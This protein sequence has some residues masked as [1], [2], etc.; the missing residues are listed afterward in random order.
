MKNKKIGLLPGSLVYTG[1]IKNEQIKISS[2]SYDSDNINIIE[3][4]NYR[5]SPHLKNNDYTH[6]INIIGIHNVEVVEKIGEIYKIDNLILEDILNVNQ[7]PKYEERKDFIFLVLKMSLFDKEKDSIQYNQI[8]FILGEHFLLT[9]QEKD[10]HIFDGIVN[11]LK[12][13]L[14]KIR[15]RKENYL[16][17]VLID[18]IID[19]YFTVFENFEEKL[20][21]LEEKIITSPSK[22]EIENIVHLKK[23]IIT[24]RKN[25]YPIRDIVSKMAHD[26]YFS[27]VNIFIRDLQDHSIIISENTEII[28]NRSI[29]LIQ[30][31]H[32]TIGN[33]MNETMKILTIISTIFI[34]LSFLT[35]IY[36]MNFQHMPILS[37]KYGYYFVMGIMASLFLG[38]IIY[39][40]IKKWW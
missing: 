28:Y 13:N 9:F 33:N 19:N 7:R 16:N 36:G 14:G 12:D 6:W 31:Y 5:N 15:K 21:I 24:F 3:H 1:D 10:N 32:S 35:G 29:E 30:L 8:S 2:F 34:P 4:D 20:N 38:M 37:L 23:D 40:K 39:F 11:K 18:L 26:E 17:Y 27:D 25:I 22:F